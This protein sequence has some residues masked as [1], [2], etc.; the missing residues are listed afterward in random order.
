MLTAFSAL[1]AAAHLLHGSVFPTHGVDWPVWGFDPARSSFN[2]AE[3][4]LTPGNVHNL[5]ERW[6]IAL[7]DIADTAPIPCIVLV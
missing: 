4:T 7:G 6:K 1:I 3:K 2:S 5:R